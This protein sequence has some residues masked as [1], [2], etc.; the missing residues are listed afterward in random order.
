M[1]KRAQKTTSQ[2][3]MEN[4]WFPCQESGTAKTHTHAHSVSESLLGAQSKGEGSDKNNQC[5][6][7]LEIHI[8]KTSLGLY[9][10]FSTCNIEFVWLEIL[11]L[12]VA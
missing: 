12:K 11:K 5:S 8:Q 4:P 7:A 1:G 2:R 10:L 3:N 9:Y 6:S